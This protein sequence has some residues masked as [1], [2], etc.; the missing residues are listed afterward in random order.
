MST[1]PNRYKSSRNGNIQSILSTLRFHSCY[2]YQ[3]VTHSFLPRTP[4][5]H[6]SHHSPYKCSFDTSQ[7]NVDTP[8]TS[9]TPASDH[10]G[11]GSATIVDEN[12]PFP[13]GLLGLVLWYK[14][15]FVEGVYSGRMPDRNGFR[16]NY[17]RIVSYHLQ[18]WYYQRG[19]RCN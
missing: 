9:T 13:P 1:T 8:S 4:F 19:S 12:H 18:H 16:R 3:V 2:S 10:C 17:Q 7:Y 14:V 11:P 6:F 15:Y 5:F